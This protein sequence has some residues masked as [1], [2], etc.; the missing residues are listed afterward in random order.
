MLF[1]VGTLDKATFPLLCVEY[2]EIPLVN[3]F[4]FYIFPKHYMLV[5]LVDVT[6]GRSVFCN[7]YLQR[8]VFVAEFKNQSSSFP[9]IIIERQP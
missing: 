6:K 2:Q 8:C 7:I 5:F 9:C 4:R 1:T 3:N